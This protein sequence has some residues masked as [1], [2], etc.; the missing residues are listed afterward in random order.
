M[1]GLKDGNNS[2]AGLAQQTPENKVDIL[3][4]TC[5]PC[6]INPDKFTVSSYK[7]NI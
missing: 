6:E 4:G 7:T 3:M 2:T 1:S 5:Q